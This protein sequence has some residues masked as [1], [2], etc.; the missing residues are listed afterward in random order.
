[1]SINLGC[2]GDKV[3]DEDLTNKDLVQKAMPLISLSRV[4]W[5]LF[6]KH[7]EEVEKSNDYSLLKVLQTLIKNQAR[8]EVIGNYNDYYADVLESPVRENSVPVQIVQ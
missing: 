3:M 6:I 4:E 7:V 2:K 5:N 1:M 8:I